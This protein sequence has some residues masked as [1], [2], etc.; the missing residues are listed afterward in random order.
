MGEA[1]ADDEFVASVRLRGGFDSNPQFLPGPNPG[2]TGFIGTDTAL[3]AG[4][5]RDGYSLGVAAEAGA[6]QYTNP[7][8]IPALSGKV[9]LRGLLGDD[10]ASIASTTT[11]GDTSSYNL[12]SSDIMQSIKGEMKFASI[13]LFASVEGARSSLNQTNVIF[14]DFLPSPQQYLRGTLIPGISLVADKFEVGT[15]VNLS[16]RRYLEELDDFGYRR[17]NERVQPFLFARYTSSDISAFG[18]IS[19]LRGTWRDVDFTNVSEVLFDTSLTWRIAPFTIDLKAV[20]KAGETTFPISPITIDT[21]YSGKI[22]WQVDPDW[23]MTAGAGYAISR[24]LDSPFKAQTATYGVGVSRDLGNGYTLGLDL[25]QAQG[26]LISGDKAEATIISSSITKKFS[27]FATGAAE[28][29]P[30]AS[31]G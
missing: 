8:L 28:E 1:M 7:D 2:R 31:K 14:Q 16:V 6:T 24:Y 26:T 10:N 25:T 21:L 27:P 23:T 11:I 30:L 20:R 13:K 12:R 19:Y 22:A 15:S 18:A 3:A 29:K 4:T 5:K 9:V 17:D